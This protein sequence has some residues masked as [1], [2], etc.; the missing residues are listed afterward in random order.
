MK[1]KCPKCGKFMKKAETFYDDDSEFD[2]DKAA[3]D[4]G[5]DEDSDSPFDDRF[6]RYWFITDQIECNCGHCIELPDS[7]R[8]YFLP[9]KNNYDWEN[10]VYPVKG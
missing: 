4:A 3:Q 9:E 1:H 7:P 2:W 5:M 8:Y 6:I 10:P